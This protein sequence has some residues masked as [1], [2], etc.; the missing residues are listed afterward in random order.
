M[1]ILIVALA[2]FTGGL[3]QT[4]SG[5]GGS[6]VIMLFLPAIMSLMDAVTL[7]QAIM[8]ILDI[9]LVVTYRRSIRFRQVLLPAVVSLVFTTIFTELAMMINVQTTKLMFGAFLIAISIYFWFF[10]LQIQGSTNWVMASACGALSGVTNGLF[11][12][13]GPPIAVYYLAASENNDA[14]I[15]TTQF[16][17]CIVTSYTIVFRFSKGLIC[18]GFWKYVLIGSLFILIGKLIGKLIYERI[19]PKTMK[20]CVYVCIFATGISTVLQSI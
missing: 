1:E 15:G 19:S 18:S 14:Y 16:F 10:P 4:V 2:A 12:I 5:F 13:G 8:I 3:V 6:L 20:K 17:F 9:S 11:G 7:N